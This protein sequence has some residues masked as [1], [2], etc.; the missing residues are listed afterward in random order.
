MFIGEV[1][2]SFL[3]EFRLERRGRLLSD[4]LAYRRR[5]GAIRACARAQDEER[6]VFGHACRVRISRRDLIITLLTWTRLLLRAL[7]LIG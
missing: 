5:R 3:L 1:L 4:R 2:L 6:A 7:R